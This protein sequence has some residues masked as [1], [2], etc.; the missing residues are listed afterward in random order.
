[1]FLN[2]LKH[3]VAAYIVLMSSCN[4]KQSSMI[5]NHRPTKFRN[6]IF[7]INKILALLVCRHIIKVYVLVAPL[8]IM[9]YSFVC[10]FFLHDK[11]VLKE[12]NDSFFYVEMVEF[13]YHGFLVFEISFVLVNESITFINHISNIIKNGAICTLIKQIKLIS[14]ILVLFLLSLKLVEHV[15]DLDEITFEFTN[16]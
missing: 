12:V 8:K 3:P 6:V 16:D 15:L 13:G 9:D 2:V 14:K 1:M 7:K 5:T 11:D 10:Q 4:T